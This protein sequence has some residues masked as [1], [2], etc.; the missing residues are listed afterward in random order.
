MSRILHTRWLLVLVTILLAA[1]L[2]L[3]GYHYFSRNSSGSDRRSSSEWFYRELGLTAGQDSIFRASKDSFMREMRPLWAQSR[4]AKD[5][6][7]SRMGDPSLDDSAVTALTARIA[8]LS[9]L[10][11]ERMFQHFRE[12]RKICTPGQQAAFDTLVPKLMSRSRGSR[13][14]SSSGQSR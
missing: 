4:R 8:E 12:L 6:L 9:R 11:D 1:N 13:S 10:S 14:S 2:A 5:S 7:F 3:I